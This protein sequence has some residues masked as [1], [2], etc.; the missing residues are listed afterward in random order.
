MT[1][2]HLLNFR[3]SLPKPYNNGQHDAVE[4]F[5]FL[6]DT[7]ALH[8]EKKGHTGDTLHSYDKK[9]S[10]CTGCGHVEQHSTSTH[11]RHID[12][13]NYSFRGLPQCLNERHEYIRVPDKDDPNLHICPD[14]LIEHTSTAVCTNEVFLCALKRF[15][16]ATT[17]DSTPVAPPLVFSDEDTLFKL[18]YVISHVGDVATSGHYIAFSFQNN[19]RILRLDDSHISET[20]L[21]D[22]NINQ[23]YLWIYTRVPTTLTT[24][25]TGKT[26]T[27]PK[28]STPSTSKTLKTTTSKT[29][30]PRANVT[31]ATTTTAPKRVRTPTRAPDTDTAV[32]TKADLTTEKRSKKKKRVPS[33]PTRMLSNSQLSTPQR[34]DLKRAKIRVASTATQRTP[35]ILINTLIK[36]KRPK[37]KRAP[38]SPTHVPTHTTPNPA[39]P[40]KQKNTD[41]ITRYRHTVDTGSIC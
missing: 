15:A 28:T 27:T 1:L 24:L 35:K 17:K 34:P 36:A 18:T 33:S 29:P 14:A 19:N 11:I 2:D 22:P 6:V 9:Q 31:L 26:T 40:G 37:K 3:A 21:N 10:T 25:K 4:F 16:T 32:V 38:S 7:L 39:T 30:T 23:G 12:I 41:A 20:T 13:N 5:S 8:E